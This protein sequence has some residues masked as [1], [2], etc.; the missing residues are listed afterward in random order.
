M[1]QLLQHPLKPYLPSLPNHLIHLKETCF[2]ALKPTYLPILVTFRPMSYDQAKCSRS[3]FDVE[4]DDGRRI[5][6]IDG[7][8]SYLII[9]DRKT[10]RH[11]TFL[12]KSKT[13]PLDQVRS[14]LHKNACHFSRRKLIR[15]DQG[16]ELYK[17]HAFQQLADSLGFI[18]EPTAPDAP[19][20]N[21]LAERPNRTL[22]EIMKCLLYQSQLGPEYWSWALLHACYLKNRL[23]HRAIGKTPFEVWSSTKPS[24]KHWRIFGCPVIVCLPGIKSAKLDSHTAH[25]I[26]LGFTATDNNIYYRDSVTKRIKTATHV[27]FDEVGMSLPPAARTPIMQ[28][29][30][31]LGYSTAN[32]DILCD[33]ETKAHRPGIEPIIDY[34]DLQIQKL[35]DNAH[36]PIRATPESAGYDL[37][38]AVEAIIQPNTRQLIATDLSIKPPPGT[39]VQLMPRS[40]LSLKYQIDTRAGV[41][42]RDYHG[43][44]MVLLENMSSV[45]FEIKN[46]DR[47]AQMI[48]HHISSPPLVTVTA[49]DPTI[50]CENGFGST[51]TDTPIARHLNDDQPLPNI[52]DPIPVQPPTTVH[53][54]ADK[55]IIEDGKRPY[56]IWFSRDPFDNRLTVQ[57]DFKGLH[58]TLGLLLRRC[59]DRNRLQLLDTALS[60]PGSR[61]A[62]W[63]STIRTSYLLSIDGKPTE[64]VQDVAQAI[65]NAKHEKRLKMSCIF[66][67]EKRYG[68]HPIDSNLN[69][70][71]DQ[72]HAFAQHIQAADLDHIQKLQEQ[73]ESNKAPPWEEPEAEGY[74]P[75]VRNLLSLNQDLLSE[76]TTLPSTP[77]EPPQDPDI[78]KSFT[79]K[80]LMQRDDWPE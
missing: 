34:A 14:F 43:N 24:A 30:H 20:Q 19:F 44:F 39:Y 11:W 42:D 52:L 36:L 62:K 7:Y 12:T 22:G 23:P 13:P 79:K 57:I 8:N 74:S 28:Q 45:P 15:T 67:T 58:P 77:V 46:G 64:T 51:G 69:L 38:S 73:G 9:I 59:T 16:G 55:I 60:T 6:S 48:L 2:G 61:I 47:I 53:D 68:V 41:I 75:T 70:Y 76:A 18:L 71:F 26:F 63:R 10:R 29:L 21:G 78:G 31:D 25:G 4:D 1:N 56:D 32:E 3:G 65:V 49:L 50:R 37:F 35:S 80:K 72:I 5:T 54:I 33:E 17:S 27:T 66:A 40:G